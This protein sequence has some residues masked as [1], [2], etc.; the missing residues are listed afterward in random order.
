M[1]P[2]LGNM[3]YIGLYKENM[4]IIFLFETTGSKA[5]ILGM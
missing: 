4:K 5:L 2:S 1:A 3:V